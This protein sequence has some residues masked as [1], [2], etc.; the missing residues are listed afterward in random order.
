MKKDK[1]ITVEKKKIPSWIL[2]AGLVII[3]AIIGI[4]KANDLLKEYQFKTS[5]NKSAYIG[6][7]KVKENATICTENDKPI[8]R[9]F[10]TTWC[11]HCRWAK[12]PFAQAVDGY[13]KQGK[14]VAHNWEIDVKDDTLTSTNEGSIPESENAVYNEFNPKGSI[15]T[16]VFGCKYYRIGSGHEIEDDKDAERREFEAVIEQLLNEV[17]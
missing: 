12:D 6:T 13:V 15:P 14:I 7:F 16:F 3:L 4:V 8:I 5:E 1:R 2:T 10:S 17:K 11:P 9:M